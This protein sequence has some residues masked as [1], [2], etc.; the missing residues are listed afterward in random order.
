ML[1]HRASQRTSIQTNLIWLGF[2][3][4]RQ[5][6]TNQTQ[7]SAF[8]GSHALHQ[9][10][11]SRKMWPTTNRFSIRTAHSELHNSI[12][13]ASAK[14]IKSVMIGRKNKVVHPHS[15]LPSKRH[16]RAN[17]PTSKANILTLT[18]INTKLW[19]KQTNKSIGCNNTKVLKDTI[20]ELN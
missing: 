18:S 16:L 11:D 20:I 10:V 14:S 17:R 9:A 7:I 2:T 1:Y 6:M 3:N 13:M 8:V 4:K 12:L 5:L 15:K 19:A